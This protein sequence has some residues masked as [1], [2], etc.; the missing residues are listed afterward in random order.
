MSF[1]IL[2]QLGLPH[3]SMSQLKKYL[4]NCKHICYKYYMYR[5]G[6]GLVTMC[7]MKQEPFKGEE[8]FLR[9]GGR[10]LTKRKRHCYHVN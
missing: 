3:T 7:S 4:G 10:F 6:R 8:G 5:L 2:Y 1:E 9:R